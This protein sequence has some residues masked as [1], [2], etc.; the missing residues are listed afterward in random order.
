MAGLSL[1][2]GFLVAMVNCLPGAGLAGH[3]GDHRGQG[4][5]GAATS[6]LPTGAAAG[7]GEGVA[8]RRPA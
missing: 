6:H 8:Q 2:L 4:Y 5:R 3:P 7:G 1:S